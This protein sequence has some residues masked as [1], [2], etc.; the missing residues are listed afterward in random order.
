[1]QADKPQDLE[2]RADK[3]GGGKH[4]LRG[5]RRSRARHTVLMKSKTVPETRE[6]KRAGG[7]KRRP[8][9][10]VTSFEGWRKEWAPA[11]C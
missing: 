11:A 8:D 10:V 4:G 9:K 1:M 6:I 3:R 5:R 2:R 7:S